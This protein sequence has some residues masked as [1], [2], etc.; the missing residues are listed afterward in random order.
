MSSLQL[1]AGIRDV[2]LNLNREVRALAVT[3]AGDAFDYRKVNVT[4]AAEYTFT[5]DT[6]VGNAG[7]CWIYNADA[8]NYIQV[9]FATTVYYLR[10]LAGQA[11][12]IPLEPGTSALYL[13]ANTADCETEVYVREA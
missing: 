10:I 6:D 11:A 5:I 4:Q 8:T 9:G 1:T 12:V 3:T 7:L 13:R 2:D